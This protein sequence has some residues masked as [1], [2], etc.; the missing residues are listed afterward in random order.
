MPR[1]MLNRRDD[2][3]LTQS[4]YG[5]DPK[6]EYQLRIRAKR[7][8]SDDRIVRIAVNVEHRGEIDL[9]PERFQLF[10][11]QPSCRF[12]QRR[13]TGSAKR[14]LTWQIRPAGDS[15]H[16]APF[17]VDAEKQRNV[18]C[19]QL[20]IMRECCYLPRVYNIFV[21]KNKST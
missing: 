8:H 7:T 12:G 11:C 19:F 14:H 16:N 15:F 13:F 6:P 2:P 5:C 10:T 17:L 4:F 21:K 20:Q 18:A 3:G 9:Q 1:K